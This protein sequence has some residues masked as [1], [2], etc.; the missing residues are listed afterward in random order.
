MSAT[1]V[2]PPT[3][4]LPPRARA[5]IYYG[6]GAVGLLLGAA[7]VAYGAYG[8]G[9]PTWLAAALA[10]LAF[11]GAGLGLTAASNT[12]TT[13]PLYEAPE[14]LPEFLPERALDANGDGIADVAGD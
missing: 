4:A 13:P 1:P 9:Q 10:V 11:L 5:A 14:P 6:Y 7:Q 2:I 8:L 3:V 12:V